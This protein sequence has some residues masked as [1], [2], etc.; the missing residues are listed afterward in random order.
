MTAPEMIQEMVR[1]A[2]AAQRVFETFTQEQCDKVARAAARVVYDHAE[3][4]A[5]MAQEETQMGTYEAKL[6]QNTS[7]I[8]WMWGH[9]KHKKAVGFSATMRKT[10]YMS[11][12]SRWVWLAVLR[13]RL[14]Q[15]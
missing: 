13:R 7:G 4:L 1:R 14:R 3:E 5:Q 12:Q 2:R 6:T 10:V 15:L 8:S 9:V 11:L